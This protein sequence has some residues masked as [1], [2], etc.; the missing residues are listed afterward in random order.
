MSRLNKIGINQINL[1]AKICQR[2]NQQ[3]KFNKQKSNSL[4]K[5][6]RGA[7][8]KRDRWCHIL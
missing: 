6:S 5:E 7:S 1:H 3:T 8:E 4:T 2:I